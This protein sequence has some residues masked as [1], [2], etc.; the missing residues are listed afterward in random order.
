[1]LEKPQDVADEMLVARLEADYGVRIVALE[2]LPLGADI[3][4]AVYRAI[5]RDGATLFVKLR[6]GAFNHASI[7][8]PSHLYDRG[9]PHVIAPI[10]T[11]DGRL[12]TRVGQF[13]LVL[14]PFVPGA[15]GFGRPLSDE[16]WVHLGKTL[17][18]LHETGWAAD[19]IA[20][21]PRENYSPGWRAFV[22]ELLTRVETE[23]FDDPAAAQYAE[24]LRDQRDIVSKLVDRTEQ[25]AESIQQ[26]GLDE[27]LCHADIHAGNVLIDDDGHLY[28]IDW[29]TLTLAP[30][31]RDLMFIGAGIGDVWN[32]EREAALFYQGYGDVDIDQEALAYF[33]CE[34]VIQDIAE[35]GK[36]LLCSDEGDEDRWQALRYFASQFEPDGVLEI[37]L[38]TARA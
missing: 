27:C 15:S 2:F 12:W 34:R 17:R 18:Q 32:T 5:R 4:T 16:Q 25:C 9:V 14:Y 24:I 8:V 23:T 26:R 3:D 11:S 21:V 37:A 30:R 22:R 36:Q 13:T 1:M 7:L 38:G 10:P 28:I 33:R 20:S 31:E 19:L 29:D 6:R 35:F